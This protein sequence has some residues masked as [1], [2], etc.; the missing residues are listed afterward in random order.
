MSETDAEAGEL[1]SYFRAIEE[2]FT[3]LRGS[4]L[5]L[6]AADFQL[7]KRWY[8]GGVPIDLVCRSL[9]EVF[10]RRRAR[11]ATG[12]VQ[13]LRYCRHA[14]ED[15]WREVQELSGVATRRRAE[16]VAVEP[17]LAALARSLP[18]ALPDR[19]RWARRIESLSGGAEEV[20][21]ALEELDRELVEERWSSLD[22]AERVRLLEQV[23]AAL[24]GVAGRLAEDDL[25][26]ARERL[27]RQRLRRAEE[28]PVLSLFSVE[29]EPGA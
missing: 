26:I 9:E 10:E 17:R 7:A 12:K 27:R 15:A 18:A 24:E 23:D 22:E 3:R 21:R 6:S 2:T 4:P 19:Q 14:V 11:G 8:E 29:A 1:R 20:E 16:P 5:L 25:A 28:L 13:G